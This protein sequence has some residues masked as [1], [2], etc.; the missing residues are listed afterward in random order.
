MASLNAAAYIT[1][2]PFTELVE[3]LIFS[4]EEQP[5]KNV[6]PQEIPAT[7]PVTPVP[8][9]T[10]Q[11][12]G[13]ESRDSHS[14]SDVTIRSDASPVQKPSDTEPA[15]PVSTTPPV[16]PNVIDGLISG[17]LGTKQSFS[18]NLGMTFVYIPPGEFLMGSPENEAERYGDEEQH[19]VNLPQG[20]YMQ[21]T[22]VTQGQWKAV[23]GKN[24]SRFQECGDDCPVENVSWNDVQIFI[25]KLNRMDGE[26]TG[27]YL[28]PIEA[29]WEYACRAGTVTRYYT[30]DSEADLDRAGW[31]FKNSGIKL[32]PVGE[33][34]PNA[35]GLYDMHGNVREWCQDW[36]RGY[37]SDSVIDLAG[38][39][40]GAFWVIRGGSWLNSARNCR[41]ADRHGYNPDDRFDVLGF[42]LILFP[43]QQ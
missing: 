34:E 22:E 32:H 33:K 11:S 28:L 40:N 25:E 24:P 3:K 5:V 9:N 36:F 6:Q 30:G 23:M 4:C 2:T 42:R 14:G 13:T 7:E 37:P 16:Q 39:E 8:A 27:T 21:T 26:R 1:N 12:D 19:R 20:F 31:Y 29:Q 43:G 17:I 18:N 35:W 15:K 41:S 38:P 10:G